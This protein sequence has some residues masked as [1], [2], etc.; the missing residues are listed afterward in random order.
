MKFKDSGIRTADFL[1]LLIRPFAQ[2]QKVFSAKAAKNIPAT[3]S[4]IDPNFN[5]IL[6]HS[7]PPR[8][9][10]DAEREAYLA[11]GQGKEAAAEFQNRRPLWH[12]LELLD[13]SVGVSGRG[14]RQCAARENLTGRRCRHRPS[15]RA[16]AYQDFLALWK[17]PDIPILKQAKAE[18]AKLQ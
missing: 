14:P 16:A 6:L 12:R 1:P 17:D 13:G 3:P 18:Y 2:S 9:N 11:A 4:Q 10:R 7:A 8:K 15:P 5:S